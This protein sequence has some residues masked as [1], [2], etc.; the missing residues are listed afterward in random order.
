M[1][2]QHVLFIACLAVSLMVSGC[3]PSPERVATMTAAA[4]T[5]TPTATSTPTATPLPT[6]TPTPTATPTPTTTPTPTASPTPTVTP[7]PTF[8]PIRQ[9]K[10]GDYVLFGRYADKPILWR[11]I[12]DSANSDAKV[13]DV[14]T[15][16][17]L[18]FS[19]KIIANKPYD[20]AGPHGNDSER[21]KEGSNLWQTSNLRAWLNSSAEAGAVTWPCGNPPVKDKVK[22]NDY[23]DE[24]GFLAA[25]NFA[26]S[27]RNLV[28][29]VTQKSVLYPVDWVMAEGGS[30]AYDY[31]GQITKIVGN[32]DR[33][34]YHNG[35][36]QVFLLDP[37][38]IN[39]VYNRFGTYYR[40]NWDEY[41]LRAPDN[42]S[43]VDSSAANV[44]T[45]AGDGDVLYRAANDGSIGVR[46]ALT[47]NRELVIFRSGDGSDAK[48]YVISGE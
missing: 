16:N 30:E 39:G 13:G 46:P 6:T 10:I 2:R 37:K 43:Y 44:L 15:G 7:V 18:L 35:T 17:P 34:R 9:M 26:E 23:A 27:E 11:V 5:A 24:Q 41:W 29:P 32:Y 25:G 14:V 42:S 47:L 8:T 22:S 31:G 36:D 19:D 28:K 21:L 40:S 4:W 20:A 1:N 38:Q 12:E 33:A 45:L 48:P 3:G